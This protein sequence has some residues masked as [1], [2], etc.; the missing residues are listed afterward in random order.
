MKEFV[1]EMHLS[2][3]IASDGKK[4]SFAYIILQGARE[5][6]RIDFIHNQIKI[7]RNQAKCQYVIKNP[8]ISGEHCEVTY[9]T[10][11][12]QFYVKNYSRN[13]T[14]TKFGALLMGQSVTLKAGEWFYLQTQSQRHLF[15]LEVNESCL[16]RK[17]R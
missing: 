11:N 3:R 8:Q 14:Y 2:H 13:Y 5:N 16:E 7:G 12:N 17:K 10:E 4:E 15:F 1:H 9:D 6:Q